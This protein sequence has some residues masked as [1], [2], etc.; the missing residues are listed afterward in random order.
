MFNKPLK[1]I[2]QN[3]FV[4]R[5]PSGIEISMQGTEIDREAA[6]KEIIAPKEEIEEVNK[7]IESLQGTTEQ[8][9]KLEAEILRLNLERQ[10]FEFL[11]LD[12]F[13]ATTSK[14]I[15]RYIG[16][17]PIT[18]G[19]YNNYTGKINISEEQ[20]EIILTILINNNLVINESGQIKIT[21]KGIQFITFLDWLIRTYGPQATITAKDF[22]VMEYKE[23]A[24]AAA[25]GK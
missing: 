3:R 20:R 9:K 23:H 21:Q 16:K 2:I 5:I 8:K 1:N 6:S 17:N 7:N 18:V 4:I 24:E 25:T 11:Y 14:L 19:L 10:Y 12:Q 13:L 22:A 15:L